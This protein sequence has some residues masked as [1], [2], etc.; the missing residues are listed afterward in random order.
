MTTL[1]VVAILLVANT[2]ILVAGVLGRGGSVDVKRPFWVPPLWIRV[3]IPLAVAGGLWFG[4]Q[5]SWWIAVAMC[6]GLLIWSGIA[7]FVL[8]VGGYFTEDGAA[9]RA[10]HVGLLVVTWLAALALLL[11]SGWSS[12]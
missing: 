6:G 5:W 11:F 12:N 4:Q 2:V 9:S 3:G 7:S 1:R 8:A 10:L